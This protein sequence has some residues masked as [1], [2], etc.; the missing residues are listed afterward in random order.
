M[1]R[2]R[3]PRIIA[4]IGGPRDG[5]QSTTDRT[6]RW[7]TYVTNDGV[8]IRNETGHSLLHNTITGRRSGRNGFYLIEP[9]GGEHAERLGITRAR[10]RVYIHSSRLAASGEG[11]PR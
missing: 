4:F 2:R 3:D 10:G 7:P 6:G 11:S 9:A 5:Q 8:S 1:P